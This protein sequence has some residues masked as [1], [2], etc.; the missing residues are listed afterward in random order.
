M[1]RLDRFQQI[2]DRPA[3]PAAPGA[4]DELVQPLRDLAM[5]LEAR[6]QVGAAVRRSGD[7]RRHHLALWPRHR[8]AFSSLMVTVHIADGRGLV[9]AQPNFPF[10]SADELT[11]WLENFV[12]LPAFN[13]LLDSLRE[14]AMEPVDARLERENGMATLATVSPE[15]QAEL[16]GLAEGAERTVDLPLND[17]E[18]EPDP[19]ALFR[20]K[21]A[22]L[23]FDI[24]APSVAGRTVHMRIIK[25][26][27]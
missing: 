13:A 18:P 11:G 12:Q 23:L 14:Q 27:P 5:A 7:G 21:S 6:S 2:L 3:P 20:L 25:R 4:A 10:A 1:N 8:P 22:G 17:T 15:L 19:A 24:R 9:L 26:R 16:D